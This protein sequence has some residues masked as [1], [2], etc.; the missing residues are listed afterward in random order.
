MTRRV[1]AEADIAVPGLLEAKEGRVVFSAPPRDS[2]E[3]WRMGPTTLKLLEV[4]VAL[5]SLCYLRA[6]NGS[7]ESSWLVIGGR[8]YR[9]WG[10]GYGMFNCG[11]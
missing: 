10:M 4:G 1:L 5:R 9:G 6:K 8:C 7:S 3:D 11:S 2:L